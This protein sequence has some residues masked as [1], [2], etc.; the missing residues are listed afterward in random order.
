MKKVLILDDEK[1]ILELWISNFKRWDLMAEVH[2]AL[3]GNDGLKLIEATGGYDLIITDYKMPI[4]DGLTFI[5]QLKSQQK[6]Q[7][8]PIFFFTG[9]MPELKSHSA[10]LENVLFFEKPLIS[11][12]MKTHIKMCLS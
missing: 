1:D 12:K 10:E 11:E 3:N 6:F 8:T 5:T 9:Y 4:M 7:K 2:T